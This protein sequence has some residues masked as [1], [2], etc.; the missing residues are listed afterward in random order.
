MLKLYYSGGSGKSDSISYAAKS[1]GQ[2]MSASE[3]FDGLNNLFPDLSALTIQNRKTEYR[4]IVL[5]NE[6]EDEVLSNLSV[7]FLDP[8]SADSDE[9]NDSLCEIQLGWVDLS[10]QNNCAIPYFPYSITDGY[11][12]PLGVTFYP[13]LGEENALDL[14][15]IEPGMALGL[16][17]KRIVKESALT[18]PSDDLLCEISEGTVVLPTTESLQ[19]VFDW[20]E[21]QASV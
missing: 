14:P 8:D 4:A 20:E 18:A 21:L 15:N 10:I 3:L 17:I 11:K 7:W 2:F 1:F 5:V 6:S 19:L 13:A 9:T 16:W 12:A